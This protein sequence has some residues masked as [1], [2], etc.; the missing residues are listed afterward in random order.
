MVRPRQRVHRGQRVPPVAVVTRRNNQKVGLKPG[1]GREDDLLKGAGESGVARG[2]GQG[3]VDGEALAFLR[4]QR[5]YF[6]RA[7]ERV[8]LMA[9]NV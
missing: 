5:V 2:S 7:G 1:Q 6:A 3:E 8:L 4:S 9:R